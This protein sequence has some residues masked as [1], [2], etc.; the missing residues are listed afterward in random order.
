MWEQR[1]SVDTYIYGTEPNEFL[2]A[3]V[4]LLP[5][6]VALCLAEGEG[7]NAVFLAESGWEVHS[8]DLTDAGVAKTRRLAEQR[9]VQVQAA[10]GDLAVYDI[11]TDRW[12][13]VVSI[14]AH[15][16]PSVRR[17]LHHRVVAAL[18]PAGMLLLEAYTPDQIGRGTGGPASA[19][20]TMTIELL[21]NELAGLE[22]IH[23]E[24]LERDI[25]EGAGHTGTGAV[26][27]VIAR[28]PS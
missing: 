23:A 22:F 3:N 5:A 8:V 9:G 10:V 21:R 20:M 26:V 17:D 14:F 19:E 6:G 15:M 28:K 16:P 2:R 1:Y 7:R 27:Q 25:V 24:E 13:L 12:D 11:G 18:K 4:S